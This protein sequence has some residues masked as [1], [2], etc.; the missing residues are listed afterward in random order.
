[1]INIGRKRRSKM[2]MQLPQEEATE[3]SSMTLVKS[4]V[5]ELKEEDVEEV[6]EEDVEEVIEEDVEEVIEV[7]EVTQK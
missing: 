7:V 6:I 5:G 2:P 4:L 3:K 1:M